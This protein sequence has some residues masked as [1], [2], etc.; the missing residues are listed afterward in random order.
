MMH[1]ELVGSNLGFFPSID[2]F[3]GKITDDPPPTPPAEMFANNKTFQK[4]LNGYIAKWIPGFRTSKGM[5]Q[6][7]VDGK[8][9]PETLS[10]RT[11][12]VTHINKRAGRA[13]LPLRYD[14][15]DVRKH[16][17]FDTVAIQAA[18]VGTPPRIPG[19]GSGNGTVPAPGNGAATAKKKISPYAIAAAVGGVALVGVGVMWYRRSQ[20][21]Y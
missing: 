5:P 15:A 9:G 8:I 6:I 17:V 13:V 2:P 1:V 16:V 7:S 10:A 4:T 11:V 3:T 18:T 12:V 14:I 21:G 20:G 19:T